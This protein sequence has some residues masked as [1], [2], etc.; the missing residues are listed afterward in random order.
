MKKTKTKSKK[1]KNLSQQLRDNA[2]R[3][4]KQQKEEALKLL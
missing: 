1:P 4:Q 3:F 2:I